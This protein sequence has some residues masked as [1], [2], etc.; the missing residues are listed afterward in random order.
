MGLTEP[1]ILRASTPH[2]LGES[3]A[4]SGIE[5]RPYGPELDAITTK[6]RFACEVVI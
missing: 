2:L 6:L 3:L 5:P 1:R 4:A